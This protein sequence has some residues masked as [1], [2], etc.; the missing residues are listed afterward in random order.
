[1][2][3]DRFEPRGTLDRLA[4]P[5]AVVYAAV[6]AVLQ[7]GVISLVM[8][9]ASNVAA[10]AISTVCYLPA[11]LWNVRCMARGEA[12]LG[13][14]SL[15]LIAAIIISPTVYIGDRWLSTYHVI[16]VTA[17]IVLPRPWSWLAFATVVIAQVP[18]VAALDSPIPGAGLYFAVTVLWRSATVLV[19]LWLVRTAR[20]LRTTRQRVTDEAVIHER[21]RIDDD[22]RHTVRPALSTI[23]A[24]GDTAY[25]FV[26]REGTQTELRWLVDESRRA[27]ADARQLI[28]SYQ[29]ALLMNEVSA[30][31]VLLEA[32]GVGTTVAVDDN[33]SART[34]DDTSSS[35]LRIGLARLLSEPGATRCSILV[36]DVDGDIRIE[37]ANRSTESHPA[38]SP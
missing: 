36:T 7:V 32:A 3:F 21:I 18:L 12:T 27:L 6:W 25:A 35:Q 37:V 24:R 15:L 38:I 2:E 10:A 33:M 17:V 26:G 31:V 19:P 4:G 20:E 11:Y 22:L 34:L 13:S 1:M 23:V 14:W 16:A 28:R 5:A 30:A 29:P 8:G 9:N